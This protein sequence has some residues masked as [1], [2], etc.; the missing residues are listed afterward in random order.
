MEQRKIY[1]SLYITAP[2]SRN[3]GISVF[4]QKGLF[5]GSK[6]PKRSV[7]GLFFQW[8]WVCFGSVFLK[9][10]SVLLIG[11][12][13]DRQLNLVEKVLT[14]LISW[15]GLYC[16]VWPNKIGNIYGSPLRILIID[17]NEIVITKWFK[18]TKEV[19]AVPKI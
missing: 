18:D 19:L 9:F 4:C 11:Y 7:L 17:V 1:C 13:G 6:G 5:F 8:K 14:G 15:E 10:G 2:D 12:T 3:N 16:H